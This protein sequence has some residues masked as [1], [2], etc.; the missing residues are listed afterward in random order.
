MGGDLLAAATRL[1]DV[2]AAENAALAALDLPAAI[3]SA[4]GKQHA[5]AAFAAALQMQTTPLAPDHRRQAEAIGRR[6]TALGEENLRLLQRAIAAQRSVI[7]I[8]ARASRRELAS[9]P[10]RYC[11]FGAPITTT[12]PRPI[13]ISSRV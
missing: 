13:A 11:A 6:L 8:I 4:A 1:T 10:A 12:R 7:D 5:A 9:R 2:I 3:A